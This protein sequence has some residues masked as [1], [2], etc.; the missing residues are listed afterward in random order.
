MKKLICAFGLLCLVA[1]LT[2]LYLRLATRSKVLADVKSPTGA[3][4]VVVRGK[5]VWSS[6]EVTAVVHTHDGREIPLGVIDLRAEWGETEYVYQADPVHHTRID[7]VKAVVGDR[8]LFRDTYF[9]NEHYAITGEIAGRKVE[10]RIGKVDNL[11]FHFA[12]TDS[13]NPAPSV[14]AKFLDFPQRLFPGA[15]FDIETT[16]NKIIPSNVT[17]Y[18]RDPNNGHLMVVSAHQNYSVRVV[19]DEVTQHL[20]TGTLHIKAQDPSI[21]LSGDFRL[22]NQLP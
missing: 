6:V 21:E 14:S 17:C 20:V 18:W 4:R 5:D 7:E 11:G 15:K 19:V 16:S 3:W 12:S 2:I 9:P 13:L 8:L 22:V 1:V 10:L